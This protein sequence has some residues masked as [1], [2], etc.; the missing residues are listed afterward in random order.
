MS[1]SKHHFLNITSTP[2]IFSRIPINGT[3]ESNAPLLPETWLIVAF[4]LPPTAIAMLLFFGIQ[5]MFSFIGSVIAVFLSTTDVSVVLAIAVS[6]ALLFFLIAL[7]QSGRRL[8]QSF[9]D[10]LSIN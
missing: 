2:I 10:S 1:L 6:A 3:Q 4:C 5:T 7:V 9:W 8:F